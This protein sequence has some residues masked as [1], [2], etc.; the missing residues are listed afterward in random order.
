MEEEYILAKKIVS[1]K[2]E[3]DYPYY[4]LLVLGLFTLIHKYRDYSNIVE[5]IFNKTNIIIDKDNIINLLKNYELCL[6]DTER[7]NIDNDTYGLSSYN[8]RF[9]LYNDNT[10]H[11]K[12]GTPYLICDS[13]SISPTCLLNVFIHE[14]NHLIKG[15]YN[16]D[17]IIKNHSEVGYYI[18]SG[19]NHFRYQYLIDK[20]VIYEY[21]YYSTLD[22]IINTIQA[23]EMM[24]FLKDMDGIIPDSNVQDYLDS[25]DKNEMGKDF[26]YDESVKLFRPMWNNDRF[27]SIIEDNMV[28]GNMKTI[29]SE[30]ESILGWGS[31]DDLAN[32]L[33]KF[34]EMD[35][36]RQYGRRY[37]SLKRHIK[38]LTRKFEKKEKKKVLNKYSFSNEALFDKM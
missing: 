36:Y 17:G 12:E 28:L 11:K 35:A 7:D 8:C 22:E 25:L 9:I 26:G 34:D 13:K 20:D 4:S 30:V 1:N 14:F 15:Y 19:L 38:V 33:D 31:F 21:D 6:V 27:R 37:D 2:Y 29:I 24:K 10:I 5:D 16:G 32:T 23:T 3:E 18:R